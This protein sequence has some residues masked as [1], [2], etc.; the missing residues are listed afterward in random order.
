MPLMAAGLCVHVHVCIHSILNIF[1][2]KNLATLT[3]YSTH[4]CSNTCTCRAHNGHALLL[5]KVCLSMCNTAQHHGTLQL[6]P[7]NS[8]TCT[9]CTC[10][11]WD[12]HGHSTSKPWQITCT[13]TLLAS[14][15][16][17]ACTSARVHH[18]GQR[19][20]A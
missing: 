8:T 4:V 14:A 12:R 11:T 1:L 2:L 5:P 15:L 20:R 16:Y 3:V 13:K 17:A 7:I 9:V 19:S 6:C 10:I 18:A